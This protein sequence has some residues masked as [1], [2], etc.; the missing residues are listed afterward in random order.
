MHAATQERITAY[1]QEI[2]RKL[3]EMTPEERAGQA[4]RR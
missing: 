3:R 2:V 4:A 1:E